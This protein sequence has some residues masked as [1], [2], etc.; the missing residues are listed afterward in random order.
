DTGRMRTE[1]E[2]REEA[3]AAGGAPLVGE[4]SASG[5]AVP[6]GWTSALHV[7]SGGTLASQLARCRTGDDAADVSVRLVVSL[8]AGAVRSGE[9]EL[10]AGA[11]EREAACIARTLAAG[12]VLPAGDA[13]AGDAAVVTLS[14]PVHLARR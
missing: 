8:R 13:H 4:P 14:V 12:V 11:G 3:H 9:V 10:S 6:A 1:R 7:Q 2:A 5:G